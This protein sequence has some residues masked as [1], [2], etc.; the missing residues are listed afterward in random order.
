VQIK[1]SKTM[2]LSLLV[3]ILFSIKVQ[4]C[5][6]IFLMEENCVFA[7]III[8][9][10]LAKLFSVFRACLICMIDF[11]VAKPLAHAAMKI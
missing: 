10:T 11:Y 7:P 5:V 2:H 4:I 8:S 3:C 1:Y 9:V 6:R